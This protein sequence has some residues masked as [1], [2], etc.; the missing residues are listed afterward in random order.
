M[1]PWTQNYDPL[2]FWPASTLLASLPIVVLFYLLAF[3][4]V[5]AA[6]S[7]A[8]GALTALLIAVLA[9]GMPVS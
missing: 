3:R 9:F 7:A 4:R 2:G 8:G 5:G 1:T 6:W